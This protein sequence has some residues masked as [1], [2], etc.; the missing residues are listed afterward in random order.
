MSRCTAPQRRDPEALQAAAVHVPD[1]DCL[2]QLLHPRTF[3]AD[4]RRGNAARQAF[5]RGGW[6][7]CST[8]LAER[9]TLVAQDRAALGQ[10][11]PIGDEL[12]FD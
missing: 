3:G 11:L 1:C 9:Q 12:R 10:A 2:R 6:L 7:R 4:A 8:I 5:W